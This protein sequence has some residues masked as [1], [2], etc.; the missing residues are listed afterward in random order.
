MAFESKSLIDTKNK[1]ENET[2]L[3]RWSKLA[4]LKVSWLCQVL[5]NRDTNNNIAL[6]IFITCI[7]LY[8][9]ANTFFFLLLFISQDIIIIKYDCI[10][11]ITISKYE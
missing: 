3:S 2:T 9:S 4:P 5:R 7:Y 10:E 6:Y 8:I 1:T 11:S